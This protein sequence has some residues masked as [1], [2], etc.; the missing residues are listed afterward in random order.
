MVH[1]LDLWGPAQELDITLTAPPVSDAYVKLEVRGSQPGLHVTD[2]AGNPLTLG[3][4]TGPYAGSYQEI[5]L[6]AQDSDGN[7]IPGI[8]MTAG[9]IRLHLSAQY[10]V[11]SAIALSALLVDGAT[12]TTL[13]SSRPDPTGLYVWGPDIDTSWYGPDGSP[14]FSDQVQVVTGAPH[15][16]IERLDT[17]MNSAGTTPAPVTHTRLVFTAQQ[18]A[19]AGYSPAQFATAVAVGYSP[20]TSGFTRLTWNQ[21]PDGSVSADLPAIDWHTRKII[22]ADQYVSFRVPWGFPAG[23]LAGALQ[24]YDADGRQYTT[25]PNTLQVTADIRP[26]SLQAA[27]YARDRAGELWQYRGE[28]YVS[29]SAY[30]YTRRPVGTGWNTYNALTPL[31]SF[32]NNGTGDLVGRDHDGVLW[33]YAGTG[34]PSAPFA[35]RARVGGGWNTYN[36]LTGDGHPDLLARDHDGVLWLYRGTGRVTAPF[37]SRIRIGAGW[38]TYNLLTGAGDITGDGHP[39]LLARDHDGVLWLYQGTGSTTTPY[40][41]RIEIGPGWQHYTHITGIGDLLVNGHTDL[42]ATDTNGTLWYYQGTGNPAAPYKARVN[43]GTGWSGYSTLL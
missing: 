36:L 27:F 32:K 9:V 1:D 38:N 17:H 41:P 8:P 5:T 7:G 26:A 40:K 35:P 2:E 43:I 34:N 23:L 16:V 37:A 13:A 20:D 30:Y 22:Q 24:I 10:P 33:Y 18:L 31:S 25:Q 11:S 15:A 4:A 29:S 39:D 21:N 3:P 12:G 14:D 42:L 6:G 28:T 19:A